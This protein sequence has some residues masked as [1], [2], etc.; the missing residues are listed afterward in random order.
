MAFPPLENSDHVA[1]PVYTDFLLSSKGDV[2]FHLIAY[3][4]SHT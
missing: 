2:P 1:V 4:Y 3:D